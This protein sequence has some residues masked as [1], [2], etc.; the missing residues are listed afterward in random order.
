MKVIPLDQESHPMLPGLP[1]GVYPYL[2][3]SASVVR[4]REVV[5]EYGYAAVPG[6]NGMKLARKTTD[7]IADP[8]MYKRGPAARSDMDAVPIDQQLF[9]YD[10]WLA[11]QQ[12]AGVPM[13]LTDSL[14]IRARDR[15]ALRSALAQ[16]KG[17]A[18]PTL[19]V[20]PL[21]P[22]WLR[23]GLSCLAEEVRAAG[24][25]VA[26]VLMDAYNGLDSAGTVS[27]LITFISSVADLPV[28][29]LR[30][31]ISAV[32]AVAY[33]AFAALSVRLG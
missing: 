12:H 23:N 3:G 14:R 26:I 18:E 17:V 22:W 6:L 19:V 16:W 25:P 30:C 1:R 24:R 31:D 5:S 8:A 9:G 4:L 2:G 32:G 33:G 11:R 28:V 15:T 27:G 13:I 10:E 21:D 7:V 29:M 20:L